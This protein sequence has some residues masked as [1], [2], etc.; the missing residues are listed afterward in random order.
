VAARPSA[1]VCRAG[2]IVPRLLAMDVERVGSIPS[3]RQPVQTV[4][5]PAEVAAA[6][7]ELRRV[8]PEGQWDAVLAEIDRLRFDQGLLPLAA[9]QAVQ[10]KLAAGWRPPVSG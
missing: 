7:A 2:K 9:V 1:K 8:A 4:T 10:A 6:W 3:P 5:V